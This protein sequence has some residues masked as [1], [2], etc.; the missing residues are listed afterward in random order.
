MNTREKQI[1]TEKINTLKCIADKEIADA[2]VRAAGNKNIIRALMLNDDGL[3]SDSATLDVIRSELNLPAP[4][5]PAFIQMGELQRILYQGKPLDKAS[6][7]TT[8]S[9]RD[10]Y[11]LEHKGRE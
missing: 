4:V 10:E 2:E 5:S 7:I 3:T 1:L 11:P 8:G 6:E 9:L